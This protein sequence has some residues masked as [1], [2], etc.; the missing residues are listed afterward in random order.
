VVD[1]GVGYGADVDQALAVIRDEAAQFGADTDWQH[2]LD[3]AP[4]VA[5]V[6]DLG[7]SAVTIRVLLRTQPGAQWDAGREFRRRVK[8]RLD[9]EGIEIPFP[10]RTVHVRY[11]GGP[12][13]GDPFAG[14]AT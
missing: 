1:V 11:Q 9:H 6:Q 14:G 4:E 2:R 8:R 13:Q 12:P 7:D 5:G 10:Q 3:G